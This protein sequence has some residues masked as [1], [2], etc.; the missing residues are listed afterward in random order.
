VVVFGSRD[1]KR[2]GGA[3]R[4]LEIGDSRWVAV[5]LDIGIEHRE[6]V[7]V[8]RNDPHASRRDVDRRA[9]QAAIV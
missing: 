5:D 9:D 1:K 7:E 2:I 8:V 6:C 4:T 3:D